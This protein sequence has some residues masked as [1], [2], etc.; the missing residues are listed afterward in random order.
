MWTKTTVLISVFKSKSIISLVDFK[1][2]PG[3]SNLIIKYSAS[4]FSASLTRLFKY[5]KVPALI[6]PSTS[7]K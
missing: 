3:V 7:A 5:W 4:A 6:S 2:P 1:S